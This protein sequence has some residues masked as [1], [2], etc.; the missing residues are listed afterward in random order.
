MY[1]PKPESGSSHRHSVSP[2]ARQM[3]DSRAIVCVDHC[4]ALVGVL[5][6]VLVIRTDVI[7]AVIDGV[8]AGRGASLR[9]PAIPR[10]KN[11]LRHRVTMWQAT[12]SVAAICLF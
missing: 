2:L 7:S 10:S 12:F 4:V 8:R 6:M 3:R 5:C 9:S 1:G 11:R